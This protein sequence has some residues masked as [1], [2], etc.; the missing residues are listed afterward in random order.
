[1]VLLVQVGGSSMALA[2]A[3]QPQGSAPGAAPASATHAAIDSAVHML[4][5]RLRQLADLSLSVVST[6]AF[7]AEARHT[8]CMPA[9]AHP[10]LRS[11]PQRVTGA[12][13]QRCVE[14]IHMLVRTFTAD[15]EPACLKGS[16]PWPLHW[17]C[18]LGCSDEAA[19]LCR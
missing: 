13:I 12:D 3:L 2:P 11:T 18:H 5:Q 8:A 14:P 6:Q 7:G 1:M 19:R 9:P 4:S 17:H 15:L 10:L 16:V